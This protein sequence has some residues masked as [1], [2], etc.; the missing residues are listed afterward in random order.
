RVLSAKING[1]E[2]PL[3]YVLANGDM[4]EIVLG[5]KSQA[6]H[7]EWLDFVKTNSAKKAIKHW[8][9]QLSRRHSRQVGRELI[10]K[11]LQQLLGRK[12]ESIQEQEVRDYLVHH[13][14]RTMDQL[15]MAIGQGERNPRQVVK[16]IFAEDRL[17]HTVPVQRQLNVRT[18]GF[19]ATF[20]A[21]SG[22]CRP[23]EGDHILGIKNGT[24]VEIHRSEC[25]HMQNINPTQVLAANWVIEAG[26]TYRVWIKASVKTQIGMLR[27]V[28][29]VCAR[30]RIAIHDVTVRRLPT[31]MS[32]I[33][34]FVEI[35][36][37]DQL[38]TLLRKLQALPAVM[39]VRRRHS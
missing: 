30:Q 15:F 10:E 20:F 11:E 37:A 31:G 25:S 5:P 18:P 35:K 13:G 32:T 23:I 29:D 7:R 9:T 24:R 28:A 22:C 38:S 6:P 33:S 3:D 21:R 19:E 27:D 1:L 36:D 12:L 8:Y 34:V 14:Y 26:R 16:R 39:Q 4:V 17:D 2:Q